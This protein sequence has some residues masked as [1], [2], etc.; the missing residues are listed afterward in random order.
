MPCHF[1]REESH[2]ATLPHNHCSA[3]FVGRP[4]SVQNLLCSGLDSGGAASAL[5][6]WSAS[7]TMTVMFWF[8]GSRLRKG[9]GH[10]WGVLQCQ[11]LAATTNLCLL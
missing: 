8:G 9:L 1:K 2:L 4:G 10:H 6:L 5:A 7:M 3:F 11:F